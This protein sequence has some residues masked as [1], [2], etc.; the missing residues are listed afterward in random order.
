MLSKI[1]ENKS[2]HSAGYDLNFFQRILFFILNLNYLKYYSNWHKTKKIKLLN[3]NAGTL[4][5]NL[6]W[7]TYGAMNWL[8]RHLSKNFI[9]FEY[10]SGG[11]T[12]YFLK[13][14]KKVVSIE[15]DKKWF[16]L[17]SKTIN[18]LKLKNIKYNLIKPQKVNK[19]TSSRY[20]SKNFD[21]NFIFENYVNSIGK[22]KDKSFDLVLV[23]GRCRVECI[24]RAISKIKRGGYLIL[25][26]AERDE[27]KDGKELL[28]K[29]KRYE[30]FGFG[31][32]LDTFWKTIIWKIT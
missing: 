13:K 27:Y 7:I 2:Y 4:D 24:R 18:R 21:K 17:V 22:Y 6:P 25:D 26:N 19:E 12:I 28:S 11:S 9:I 10:G 3:P 15:H 5:I 32:Y 31:P 14:C 16:T 30:F 1:F 23:D 8:N 29:Y 20:I